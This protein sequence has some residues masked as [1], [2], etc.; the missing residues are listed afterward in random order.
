[1]KTYFKKMAKG[2]GFARQGRMVWFAGEMEKIATEGAN[3]AQKIEGIKLI[4]DIDELTAGI[5]TELKKVVDTAYALA[6]AENNKEKDPKDKMNAR[7]LG[8]LKDSL[9]AAAVLAKRTI[10]GAATR[11]KEDLKKAAETAAKEMG[12]Q[13]GQVYK[14]AEEERRKSVYEVYRTGFT[15]ANGFDFGRS[16]LEY[17]VGDEKKVDGE[18]AGNFQLAVEEM[19][20]QVYIT[21]GPEAAKKL[22]DKFEKNTDLPDAKEY[23]YQ[24]GQKENNLI[25][26]PD[27]NLGRATDEKIITFNPDGKMPLVG[28]IWGYIHAADN[29]FPDNEVGKA[30]KQKYF[31]H[32][33]SMGKEIADGKILLRE[34]KLLTPAMWASQNVTADKPDKNV[35]LL[36]TADLSPGNAKEEYARKF[37]RLI[38]DEKVR[39]RLHSILVGAL[40]ASK[41]QADWPMIIQDQLKGMGITL[42]TIGTLKEEK[43]PKADKMNYGDVDPETLGT[44][45]QWL[46][47][48]V[49]GLDQAASAYFGSDDKEKAAFRQKYRDYLTSALKKND[50]SGLA[51]ALKAVGETSDMDALRRAWSA[52]RMNLDTPSEFW[53]KQKDAAKKPPTTEEKSKEGGKESDKKNKKGGKAPAEPGAV[54]GDAGGTAEPGPLAGPGAT[55]QAA[56]GGTPPGAPRH[57]PAAPAAGPRAPE[58][59]AQRPKVK[60]EPPSFLPK[61]LRDSHEASINDT[62]VDITIGPKVLKDGAWIGVP[63]STPDSQRTE[64]QGKVDSL[65][66]NSAAV[67]KYEV[68][69]GEGK[70]KVVVEVNSDKITFT[71]NIPPTPP[72][73]PSRNPYA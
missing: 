58:R 4:K 6:E 63:P 56:P 25:D 38:S 3:I 61:N 2:Y 10:E 18:S 13:L 31:E 12:T 36:S 42:E 60:W 70:Q 28:A 20:K 41:D 37:V 8:R 30:Q 62:V 7:E 45:G 26:D 17:F 46:K 50:P 27:F 40:G 59:T 65:K 21:E 23:R 1:M 5:D 72:T 34:G 44:L 14:K 64:L 32:L 54:A 57:T 71:E 39:E 35:D 48:Y 53:K 66:K 9:N 19:I 68:D 15:D 47:D 29:F 16:H 67:G 22:F 55:P 73:P 69:Y 49:A 43:L 11:K 52:M 51:A 33:R 24:R